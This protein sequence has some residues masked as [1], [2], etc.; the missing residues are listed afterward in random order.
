MSWLDKE[1]KLSA[2]PWIKENAP[3]NGPFIVYF[4]NGYEYWSATT[5]INESE[6]KQVRWEM[7][8]KDGK[9]A[10]GN[11]YGY[12]ING[13]IKQIISWKDGVKNGVNVRFYPNGHLSDQEYFVNG[14]LHGH[15]F[16]FN[17]PGH[18][19]DYR[20]FEHG[21]HLKKEINLK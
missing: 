2:I 20:L 1:K 3:K 16:H 19:E 14:K 4:K 18:V 11:S 5:D 7:Y 8:F 15:R 6:T 13:M 21:E 17:P 12:Y 10:D 9:R